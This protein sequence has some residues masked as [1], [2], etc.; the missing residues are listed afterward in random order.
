MNPEW[1]E[2]KKLRA[3]AELALREGETGHADIIEWFKNEPPITGIGK[4][5]LA[6]ALS[7]QWRR[8]GRPD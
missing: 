4:I 6:R 7:D 8:L 2:Q 5:A 1:P 3:R